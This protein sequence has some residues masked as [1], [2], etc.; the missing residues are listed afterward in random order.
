MVAN[1]LGF[2][3]LGDSLLVASGFALCNAAKVL[4]AFL[5]M[6]RALPGR[7]H[8]FATRH[9][10]TFTLVASVLAPLVGALIGATLVNTI[11]GSPF[12]GFEDLVDSPRHGISACHAGHPQLER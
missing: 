6:R 12:W 5:V 10:I 4:G 8:R 7:W 2:L 11:Y 1:F 9:D 3:A